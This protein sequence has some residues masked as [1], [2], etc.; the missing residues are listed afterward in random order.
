MATSIKIGHA[1]SST[2]GIVVRTDY[3]VISKLEPDLLLRFKDRT[4]AEKAAAICEAACANDTIYYSQ[5]NR[6]SFVIQALK[7][8]ND[9][10]KIVTS[11]CTDCSGFVS[12]CAY[13]AGA[14]ISSYTYDCSTIKDGF[15]ESGDFEIFEEEK[16]LKSTDYLQRGDILV[17]TWKK[18]GSRHALMV[19]EDGSKATAFVSSLSITSELKSIGIKSIN[20]DVTLKKIEGG[21]ESSLSDLETINSYDWSYTAIPLTNNSETVDKSL[22]VSSDT[23]NFTV[24]PLIAN[25]T[26]LLRIRAKSKDSETEFFSKNIIFT[27]LMSLQPEIIDVNLAYDKSDV[28]NNKCTLNFSGANL[29]LATGYRISLLANNK[30]IYSNDTLVTSENSISFYLK[31]LVSLGEEINYFDSIQVGIHVKSEQI[32]DFTLIPIYCSKAIFLTPYGNKIDKAF[33]KIL[34]KYKHAKINIK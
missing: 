2:I 1:S 22:S 12:S 30:V 25:T 6:G 31:D 26:Y 10:S 23:F 14:S 4:M 3:E 13:L 18:N 27:T 19:L 29:N 8:N 5:S 20:I 34:D 11:C 17:R 7:V 16:Y 15:K 24:E 33:I 21:E 9:P 32:Q 28:L